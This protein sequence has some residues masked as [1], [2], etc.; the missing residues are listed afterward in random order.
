MKKRIYIAYTGGTIGMV[1]STDGYAPLAGYLGEQMALMPE[2]KADVMPDY[3]INEY[4]T[5]L[6]SANMNPHHWSLIAQDIAD[7]YDEYDGFVVLH[8]TDTM[9]Y[10]A[11]ALSF[12]LQHLA[13]PV[14]I[15]GSQIPLCEVRNDA[16]ENI[17]TALAI[18]ANFDIPEVA[19]F[20]GNKLFRGSRSVKVNAIGLD[21]FTSPNFP[22][23]GI[24]GVRININWNIIR[25]KPTPPD[26]RLHV[27]TIDESAAVGALRIFPG[28]SGQMIDNILQPPLKGLVL[29]TYGAGNGPQDNKEFIAALTRATE[30]GL[31]IVNCSQ[32]LYGGVTQDDYSTG[33]A[34][35]R[36][37]V[38]SGY[39]MTVEATLTKLLY[40]FSCGYDTPTIRKYMQ[41]NLRGELTHPQPT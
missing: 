21:A 10:T 23:I 25:P 33:L 22:P 1:K 19:L 5:L 40:L 32:C 30:R 4:E 28:I 17:I 36:A 11:S 15:T 35:A 29:E 6:D 16:R 31:I 3:T 13:K 34:L 37:G 8:G 24:A 18:A 9:A 27:Q 20:F 2:L 41:Q 39:D 12:I 26:V 38:I 7:H 14:I